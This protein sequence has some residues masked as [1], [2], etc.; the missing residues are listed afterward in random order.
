MNRNEKPNKT[1]QVCIFS[2]SFFSASFSL[3]FFVLIFSSTTTLLPPKR[4]AAVLVADLDGLLLG[5]D[6]VLLELQLGDHALEALGPLG[7]GGQL[8]VGGGALP[9]GPLEVALG[10]PL[11]GPLAAAGGVRGHRQEGGGRELG[12]GGPVEGA[13]QQLRQRG[14][15]RRGVEGGHLRL[16]VHE[17]QVL[18]GARLVLDQL[19]PRP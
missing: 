15:V 8:V 14:E 13:V 5:S 19:Q 7:A 9:L 18:L 12:E 16:A 17:H 6:D 4:D 3:L 10:G 1:K 11:G 2:L